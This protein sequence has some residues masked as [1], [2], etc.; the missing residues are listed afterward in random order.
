MRF[1]MLGTT[2]ESHDTGTFASRREIVITLIACVV[3]FALA[4][5]V[6]AIDEA[7]QFARAHESWE[8]D[9][10]FT[11]VV[12][13][14]VAFAV[15][16]LRRWRE[17]R[18]EMK[19]RNEADIR[20]RSSE[21]RFAT[22]FG[23][24]PQPT[25]ITELATECVVDANDA[26]EALSGYTTET[27]LGR[28]LT[29]LRIWHRQDHGLAVNRRLS[30]DRSVRDFETEIRAANGTIHQ[31]MFSAVVVDVA[32]RECALCSVTD[33]TNQKSLES[34]LAHQAFHD[35]LTG[36]ANRA[37][38]RNRT[39][40][41]LARRE[42]RAGNTV[43]VLYLDLDDFKRVN[44]GLG[45]A[46]GDSLLRSVAGRLL[47]ATRQTDTVARLGGD[48]FAVVLDLAD[49]DSEATLVAERIAAAFRK[50]VQVMGRD[51]A[52]AA[53]I[54]LAVAAPDDDCDTLLRNAD[55]AMYSAK[56][57]GKAQVVAFETSMGHER[58]DRIELETGLQQAIEG[59]ELRLVFQPIV[60]LES[61]VPQ[62]VEALVRWEHPTRGTVSPASFIPIAEE[63]GLILPL[64][65]WVLMEA[66]RTAAAW[67]TTGLRL[68]SAAGP[69]P[70][71]VNVSGRQLLDA[72]FVGDV[73]HALAASGLPASA[74]V[75]EITETVLMKDTERAL[76]AMRALK[77]LGVSLAIDDFG[78][79]Y[80]SLSYLRQFPVDVLKIDRSFIQGVAASGK[81]A[82]LARTIIA[83]GEMLSLKTVAEGI[84]SA[85]QRSHLQELGCFLGQG[86]L[87][88]RPVSQSEIN[89]L[90]GGDEAARATGGEEP[91]ER[92]RLIA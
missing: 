51:V 83:L 25:V 82:A 86:F 37:L 59:G 61:G 52:V 35:P 21:R 62:S 19:A 64:G 65:R 22:A 63:T 27:M 49:G 2:D 15:F 53:S 68:A 36:L 58:L 13:L 76:V 69:I 14:G 40:L 79:G 73:R 12:V 75:L 74:L 11:L 46:A 45:H 67:Q 42:R 6:D 30:D 55:V 5:A 31:V 7:M 91:A 92:E 66:C 3:T 60:D 43:A 48:E 20:V 29:E 78:T 54:G 56:S 10:M 18:R 77:E 80:S 84:E 1:P 70:V 88:A 89:V 50:P 90:L 47:S 39:E 8:L 72:A 9:E 85:A 34:E 32:G 26:F 24:S 57:K 38:F 28:S 87:F 33:V 16:A 71:T 44:D 23:A 17:L 81:E 4:V 41:A